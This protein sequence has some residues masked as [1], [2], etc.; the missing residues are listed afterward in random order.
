MG[1]FPFVVRVYGIYI[2]PERGVLVSDEYIYGRKVTK[3]PGGGLEFGEGTLDCLVRE[4]QEETGLEFRV[5][6]H[7]YTTDFFVPSAFDP[8]LQVISVYYTMEPS[9]DLLPEVSGSPFDFTEL[10]EGAQSM[11]FIPMNEISGEHFTL[12]IDRHVGRLLAVNE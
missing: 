7:F 4:M 8:T 3:F 5:T 2:H 12:E 9:G 1:R 11:R 6:G 10:K